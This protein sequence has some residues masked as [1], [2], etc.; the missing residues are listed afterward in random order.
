MLISQ[1]TCREL[2]SN[3]SVKLKP[4]LIKLLDFSVSKILNVTPVDTN[5]CLDTFSCHDMS[6][7]CVPLFGQRPSVSSLSLDFSEI[8]GYGGS[9][10]LGHS[11]SQTENSCVK[12]NCEAPP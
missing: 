2:L 3:D 12:V 9:C 5:G 7:A 8:K 10:T 11:D 1:I 6:S 4:H